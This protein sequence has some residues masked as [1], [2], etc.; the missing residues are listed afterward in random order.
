MFYVYR[1]IKH[2]SFK[3]FLEGEKN[4]V[5]ITEA[6]QLPQHLDVKILKR[7]AKGTATRTYFAEMPR[8]IGKVAIKYI[9]NG[10]EQFMKLIKTPR[11]YEELYETDI[12]I[13]LSLLRLCTTSVLQNCLPNLPV[14]YQNSYCPSTNEIMTVTE[15]ANKDLEDWISG[16]TKRIT[17]K[18]WR[19]VLAQ[20]YAGLLFLQNFGIV[21]N[22]LHWG[23]ILVHNLGRPLLL[24][25][26][27]GNKDYYIPSPS[28]DIFVLWD[29]EMSYVIGKTRIDHLTETELAYS[30]VLDYYRISKAPDWALDEKYQTM[31]Y[32]KETVEIIDYYANKKIKLGNLFEMLYSDMTK[33]PPGLSQMDIFDSYQL[34]VLPKILSD[35]HI[36]LL[37]DKDKVEIPPTP[38]Q[39]DFNQLREITV[40]SGSDTTT[41]KAAIQAVENYRTPTSA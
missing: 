8:G 13:E 36:Y 1:F 2:R 39:I 18:E 31:V 22:D 15:L 14:L 17:E 21:H 25:Y 6:D 5:C 23:N 29:F 16:S 38:K 20:V 34:D 9:S 7:I 28:G 12:F 32:P 11:T 26:R 19:M 10:T 3:S 33:M 24:H 35:E 41:F 37:T 27:F 30:D 4:T 40:L